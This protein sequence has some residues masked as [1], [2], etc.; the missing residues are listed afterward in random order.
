MKD[1]WKMVKL[2]DVCRIKGGKRLPQGKSLIK[3]ATPFRYIRVADF[4]DN[5]TVIPDD[6]L[7][8]EENV[9]NQISQYHYISLC[10]RKMYLYR[11]TQLHRGLF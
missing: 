5:G 1:G 10:L 2:G 11:L 7:Y 6:V 9:Y 8:I 4:K 3:E